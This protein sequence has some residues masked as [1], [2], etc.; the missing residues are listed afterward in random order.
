MRTRFRHRQSDAHADV[1][2]AHRRAK[3]CKP[4][5]CRLFVMLAMLTA[6]PLYSDTNREPDA[7]AQ[8][9]KTEAIELLGQLQR[10]ERKLLYPAHTRVSVFLSLAQNNPVDP[11]AIRL[12]IDNKAVTHHVYTERE[13][14]A[15]RAGGIQRL[16]TGNILTGTHT[17][18]VAL[19]ESLKNGRVRKHEVEYSFNKDENIKYIEIIAGSI[20][21]RVTIKSRN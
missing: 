19:D 5:L 7:S 8:A 11:Q 14:K 15:L 17:L 9:I 20:E 2:C 1:R 18:Q 3:R 13:A 16:Y 6:S 10:L 21:P 4:L 12:E